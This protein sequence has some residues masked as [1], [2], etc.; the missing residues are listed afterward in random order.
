MQKCKSGHWTFAVL[1]QQ[2]QNDLVARFS[3]PWFPCSVWMFMHG[4]D[5]P[6]IFLHGNG[7]SA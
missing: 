7:R 4:T 3:F 6:L 1:R 2:Y 5:I